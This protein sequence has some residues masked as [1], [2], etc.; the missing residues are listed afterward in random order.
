VS[1]VNDGYDKVLKIACGAHFSLCYTECGILY[2]WGMLI[3]DDVESIQWYPN[4][5]SISYPKES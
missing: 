3:P 1:D 4:F 5:L 2:Y